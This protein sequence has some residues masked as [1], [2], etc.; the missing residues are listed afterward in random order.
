MECAGTWRS[1]AVCNADDI[2]RIN[3]DIPPEIAACLPVGPVTAVRLL[4]DFVDLV[5]GMTLL[6]S[7]KETHK[8]LQ[9]MW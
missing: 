9:M 6:Y 3:K 8:C 2:M 7:P 1:E 4:E 5:Q